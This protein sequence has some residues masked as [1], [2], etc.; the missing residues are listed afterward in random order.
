MGTASVKRAGGRFIAGN[1]LRALACLVVLFWHV[2]VNASALI[3]P[4]GISA[5]YEYELGLLGR[6]I[7]TLS[8]SVWFFFALSGYLVAGPFVRAFV[9]GGSRRPAV[10]PY[11]RNRALRILPAFWF[12]V[13]LTL[14]VIGTQGDSLEHIALFYGFAHVYDQGPFTPR[15]VQ[16]WTLDVEIVFYI[17]LP[18]LFAPLTRLVRD[19]GAPWLRAA[20]VLAGCAALALVSISLGERWPTSGRIVPGAAWAFTPGI[21]LATI[22]PLVRPRLE[23]RRVTRQLGWL[24]IALAVAAFLAA[25]YAID[26]GNNRKQNA[27]AIVVVSGLLAGPRLFEWA[28]GRGGRLLDNRVLHWIGI[29]A[30]GI[31]LAHVLVL[32]LLRPMTEN[33][34]SVKV[35]LITTFPLVTAVSVALGAL[36]YKF[37]ERPFLE[38]R[39]PWRS[40]DQAVAVE[41]TATVAG[42]QP[43][44]PRP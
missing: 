40:G 21:A 20:L 29:R 8:F 36:S 4:A 23:G 38:R 22:E 9:R 12:F 43:A 18:L 35:A 33:L 37:V 2:V 24:L 5:Y 10:L 7:Y 31:Y 34:S 42:P 3:P 11:L 15:M 30:Y 32:R 26:F 13:T 39:M 6:P 14:I 1:P 41:A 25:S 28:S 16:A 27:A 17:A 44:M 19:R